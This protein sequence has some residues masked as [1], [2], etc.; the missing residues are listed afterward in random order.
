MNEE[1]NYINAKLLKEHIKYYSSGNRQY[2]GRIPGRIKKIRGNESKCL[3]NSLLS[4]KFSLKWHWGRIW[5]FVRLWEANQMKHR[6]SGFIFSVWHKL[7]DFWISYLNFSGVSF[8]TCNM[9]MIIKIYFHVN[10]EFN[11]M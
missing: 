6:L 3:V 7:C 10:L 9:K 2:Y 1:F 5:Y 8:L 4:Q 11:T